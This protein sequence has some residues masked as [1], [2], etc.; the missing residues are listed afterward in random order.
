M[1]KFASHILAGV[2]LF[3]VFTAAMIGLFLF[4]GWFLLFAAVISG[5]YVGYRMKVKEDK[6]HTDGWMKELGI[7]KH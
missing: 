7:T 2:F 4:I 1:N 6:D 3:G 5:G